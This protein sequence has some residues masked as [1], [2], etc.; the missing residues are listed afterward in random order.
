MMNIEKL[1]PCDTLSELEKSIL[2][3]IVSNIDKC[4]EL[5]VRG[6]ARET[7]TSPSTVIRLSK[8]LGYKGY[9]ELVYAVRSKVLS[10]AAENVFAAFEEKNLFMTTVPDAVE[11]FI[12]YLETGNLFIFSTGFS[13]IVGEYMFKKLLTIGKK[14]LKT[15]CIELDILYDNYPEPINTILVVSKSGETQ[16]CVSTAQFAREKGIQVISFCGNPQSTLTEL[17]DVAFI[18]KDYE[19][20]DDHNYYPNPFFGYCIELFELLLFKYFSKFKDYQNSEKSP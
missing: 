12:K 15:N 3:Y 6:L 17:S 2:V 8:K 7:F 19:G 14:C 4:M 20:A 16:Y 10:P 9:V 11:R 18:V 1:F 5:G 13:D